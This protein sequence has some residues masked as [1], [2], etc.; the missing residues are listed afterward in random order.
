VLD[1][2]HRVRTPQPQRRQSLAE[3]AEFDRGRDRAVAVHASTL[4][5]R[6]L[7]VDVVRDIATRDRG[8]FL[9][10]FAA[11]EFARGA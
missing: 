4:G 8:G 1:R 6:A 3:L 7:D 9:S 10:S 2:A 5:E 11:E